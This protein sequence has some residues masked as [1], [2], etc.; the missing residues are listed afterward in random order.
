M[1]IYHFCWCLT[2]ILQLSC[3]HHLSAPARTDWREA[4]ELTEAKPTMWGSQTVVE[5]DMGQ[6]T[7]WEVIINVIPSLKSNR[8]ISRNARN[9]RKTMLNPS[10]SPKNDAWNPKSPK[11]SWPRSQTRTVHNWRQGTNPIGRENQPSG[12]VRCDIKRALKVWP[13]GES[14]FLRVG[15]KQHMRS[16]NE[17]LGVFRWFH[18]ERCW[19]NMPYSNGD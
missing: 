19:L 16:T 18:Q 8:N 7:G 17:K 12:I 5:V 10:F 15:T 4:P 11:I 1:N 2:A 6:R 13:R 14:S 3:H 9:D